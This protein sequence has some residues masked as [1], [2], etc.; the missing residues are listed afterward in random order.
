[1]S[2]INQVL[3]DL[4]RRHADGAEN[5][6]L[7]RAVRPPPR[8]RSYR[9]LWLAFALC[10]AG[11]IG[12]GVWW[13][14]FRPQSP[15]VAATAGGNANPAGSPGGVPAPSPNAGLSSAQPP[16]TAAAGAPAPAPGP[17][18][19]LPQPTGPTTGNLGAP[20]VS[21]TQTA[22]VVDA[23]PG[24]SSVAP[25]QTSMGQ[26]G[27]AQ[28]S[29]V[30]TAAASR[31]DQVTEEAPKLAAKVARKPK[32][33]PGAG[34]GA[35]G[36]GQQG[37][38]ISEYPEPDGVQQQANIQKQVRAPSDRERAEAELRQGLIALQGGNVPDAEDRLRQA[39]AIDPLTDKARQALLGLYVQRGRR[40]DAE[41]LLDE[42]LRIDSRHAGF[43]MALA[44]LQ[45]ERDGNGEALVT[46]QRSAPY[47]ESS[48]DYQAMFGNALSRVGRHKEAAQRYQIATQLA[49]Q[50]ALWYMGLG[51]ELKA[52]NRP[53]EARAALE[54]ARDL[55]GLNSQL[56]S[57]VDQQIRDLR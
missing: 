44:R 2:L 50:S 20:A 25:P 1:M 28:S 6:R 41:R 12:A 16:A 30:Q 3:K 14:E 38:G 19:G 7:A 53:G 24:R 21:P 37:P 46:L 56:A 26:A 17:I 55:G 52:D 18:A 49:P 23:L 4:E 32:R 31:P 34:D 22:P 39:L 33:K 29:P 15:S 40:E 11:V 48:A 43:A 5:R 10:I 13:F 9:P 36:Q 45:L 47:G 57:Y 51:M 27:P 54:R 42:R 35:S 8:Q